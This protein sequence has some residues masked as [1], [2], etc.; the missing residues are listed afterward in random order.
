[1]KIRER[2]TQEIVERDLFHTYVEKNAE[3]LPTYEELG[4]DKEKIETEGSV[5]IVYVYDC[6]RDYYE[7]NK[8]RIEREVDEILIEALVEGG[9]VKQP[10]SLLSG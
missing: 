2:I 7:R 9:R 6:M 5:W 4:Y 8:E 1:M 10:L 3:K